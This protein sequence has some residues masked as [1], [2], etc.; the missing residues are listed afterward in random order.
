MTQVSDVF[1][2]YN[3][4]P[5][6]PCCYPLHSIYFLHL[7]SINHKCTQRCYFPLLYKPLL[8]S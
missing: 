2:A 7:L 1:S 4:I 6:L 5:H 3:I 8:R